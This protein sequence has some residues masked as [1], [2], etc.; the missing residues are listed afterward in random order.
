MFIVPGVLK[1]VSFTWFGS[2]FVMVAKKEKY[3]HNGYGNVS[4]RE[5]HFLANVFS[6]S[7]VRLFI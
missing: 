3:A 4:N 1:D 2:P 5:V 7:M 6:F